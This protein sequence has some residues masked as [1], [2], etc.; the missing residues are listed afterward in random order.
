MEKTNAHPETSTLEQEYD[1][2]LQ[3]AL[4]RPGVREVMQAYKTWR[5]LDGRLSA[6]RRAARKAF[7][8]T[9]TSHANPQ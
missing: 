2:M 9:A 7:K 8:I 4:A 6:Y 1:A 3:K 5:E